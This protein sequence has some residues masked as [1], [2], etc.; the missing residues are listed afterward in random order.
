LGTDHSQMRGGNGLADCFT[1]SL[2]IPLFKFFG[3]TRNTLETDYTVDIVPP[4][5]ARMNAAGWQK[6][7]TGY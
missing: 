3:G 1:E 5:I 6:P 4:D 2:D 7:D